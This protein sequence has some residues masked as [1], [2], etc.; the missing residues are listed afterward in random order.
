MLI[1]CKKILGYNGRAVVCEI[2]GDEAFAKYA[3]VL[4]TAYPSSSADIWVDLSN[5]LETFYQ[6]DDFNEPFTSDLL[7]L[8]NE[9]LQKAIETDH[10]QSFIE[11]IKKGELVDI[12]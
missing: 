8:V 6:H 4:T 7:P 5:H 1:S 10:Y 12:F 9:R 2:E 3:C 11:A